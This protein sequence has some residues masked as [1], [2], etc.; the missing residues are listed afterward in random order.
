M[1]S[2]VKAQSISLYIFLLFYGLISLNIINSSTKFFF[3]ISILIYLNLLL[4]LAK[5]NQ[6]LRSNFISVFYI[7]FLVYLASMLI[8]ISL[9]QADTLSSPYF[10]EF[11]F[12]II[13]FFSSY[14]AGDQFLS[15]LLSLIESILIPVFLLMCYLSVVTPLGS[16]M[17]RFEG[18]ESFL[19]YAY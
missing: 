4:S 14:F 10:R 1:Y 3:I 13:F 2:L 5:D 15:R 7:C 18:G 12:Y 17:E 11:F 16:A 6:H 9:V 19:G 8:P